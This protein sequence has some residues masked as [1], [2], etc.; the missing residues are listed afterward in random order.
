MSMVSFET[1]HT[2]NGRVAIPE[3]DN[4]SKKRKLEDPQ[5][6]G[7]LEKRWRSS[8]T[9]RST[10]DIELHLDTPL[11][12][13]WQRCLDI[14]SGEIHFYNTRTQKRTSKDPRESPEPPTS[15]VHM[16]LDLELNL[17]CDTQRKHHANGHHRTPNSGIAKKG[18]SDIL[19]DSNR[20]RNNNSEG[21]NPCP[22]W[23]KF[24][25]DDHHQQEMVATVCTKCHM[26]VM[27]CRSSPACPNCKF[28]H[29]PD[30][31]PPRLFKPSCA[32]Y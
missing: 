14:Q 2:P 4:F 5:T 3:L 32:N 6:E 17:P 28:V 29:S 27:L 15:P 26:L 20:D 25:G 21:P 11:P 19:F 7:F 31:S 10:F 16:S 24:Q 1:P 13:E 12:M 18:F 9:M 30:Q 22:S 8:D 23:L